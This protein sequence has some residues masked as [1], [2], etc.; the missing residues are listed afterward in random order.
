MGDEWQAIRLV[1]AGAVP[2]PYFNVKGQST[3]DLA[4][5]QFGA[6]ESGHRIIGSLGHCVI[7]DLRLVIGDWSIG[8]SAHR[9][10]G[11]LG[12]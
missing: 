6:E 11:S 3:L 2:A 12:H 7:G 10:I 4:L 8:S 5:R 1:H 9:A